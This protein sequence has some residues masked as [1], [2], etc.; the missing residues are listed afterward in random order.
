MRDYYNKRE[1]PMVMMPWVILIKI[2]IILIKDSFEN[3]PIPILVRLQTNN[4]I[5]LYS[6]CI[7]GIETKIFI[8]SNSS[9]KITMIFNY[10]VHP[11]M[12]I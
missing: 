10:F 12:V 9:E 5:L 6:F 8:C 11:R 2:K 7:V 3:L 1:I 4:I